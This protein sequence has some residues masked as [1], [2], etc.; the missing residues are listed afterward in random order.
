[1]AS[2]LVVRDD[3]RR[4]L[5]EACDYYDDHRRGY[6]QLFAE[7]V[8]HELGLLME[9]P[10]IGKSVGAAVHRRTL[11]DWPY[12]IYYRLRD[13]ELIIIAVAHHRRRPG[14]W[15]SRLR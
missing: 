13:E 12:S 9:F 4:E 6:G 14:Y 8:E 15:R 11:S 1:M 5:L 7:A 3:A 10:S 2:V